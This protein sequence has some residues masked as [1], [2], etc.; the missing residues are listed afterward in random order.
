MRQDGLG[1]D[2]SNE[3]V[4]GLDL[5]LVDQEP[6]DEQR[7]DDCT[8]QRLGCDQGPQDQVLVDQIHG[9][10]HGLVDQGPRGVQNLADNRLEDLNFLVDQG[11]TC[12]QE[13]MDFE[14]GAGGS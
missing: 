9:R 2:R 4:H 5:E 14:A 7:L 13:L 8:F 10:G 3:G 6:K 12:M 1:G 11:H